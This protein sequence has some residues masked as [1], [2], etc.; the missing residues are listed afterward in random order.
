LE[1]VRKVSKKKVAKLVVLVKRSSKFCVAKYD[2]FAPVQK[3]LKI[4]AS[5]HWRE[6]GE[7]AP[8]N[9]KT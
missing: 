9:P 7:L 2:H 6:A 3:F 4:P 1:K 5:A 8:R